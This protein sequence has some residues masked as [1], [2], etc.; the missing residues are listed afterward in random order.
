MLKLATFDPY[1]TS[2]EHR[3]LLDSNDPTS[4]RAVA[5]VTP[6]GRRTTWLASDILTALGARR[7]VTGGVGTKQNDDWDLVPI[8]LEAHQLDQ[9]IILQAQR[10]H[11][12]VLEALLELTAETPTTVV[13]APEGP[14]TS[15]AL[16]LIEP[17]EP[18]RL[19][20]RDLLTD[21]ASRP[22]D[23]NTAFPTVPIT[24]FPTFRADCK[25][26]LP[27]DDFAVVDERYRTAFGQA[28]STF[29]HVEPDDETVMAVYDDLADSCR[30]TDELLVAARA[31]QAAAFRA[32]AYVRVD[33]D[34]YLVAADT[35]PTSAR[36]TP[37]VWRQVAAYPRPWVGAAIAATA[38]G[39][40]PADIVEL[41]VDQLAD[42]G[43]AIHNPDGTSTAIDPNAQVYVRAL[44][45]QLQRAGASPDAVAFVD[46]RSRP[47]TLRAVCDMLATA[48]LELGVPTVHG[49]VLRRPAAATTRLGRTG[50]SVTRIV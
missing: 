28:R 21:V 16:K 3:R 29:V 19:D 37:Q 43:T 15:N 7:N 12:P 11:L 18:I 50:L 39:I 45:I 14:L 6:G 2:S 48:R 1:L 34:T 13:L 49:R 40:A 25:A 36:R 33:V 44:K 10:L 46:T 20:G 47:V 27:A 17:H 22:A 30:T 8:W 4:G 38:A 32:G 26:T 24:D 31:L 5:T 42:D 23:V 41:T 35:M 9:L